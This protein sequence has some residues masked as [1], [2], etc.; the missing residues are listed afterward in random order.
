VEK[1][2]RHRRSLSR[3]LDPV[4][5][6]YLAIWN[7][8]VFSRPKLTRAVNEVCRDLFPSERVGYAPKEYT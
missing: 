6:Q 4:E 8:F 3:D 7:F 5:A 1:L 2:H